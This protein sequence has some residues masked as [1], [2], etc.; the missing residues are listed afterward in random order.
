MRYHGHYIRAL[1]NTYPSQ[2]REAAGWECII[3]A[4]Q[5]TWYEDSERALPASADQRDHLHHAG[6]L[7]V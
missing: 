2:E 1:T 3:T 6:C 7:Y 4:G 5:G